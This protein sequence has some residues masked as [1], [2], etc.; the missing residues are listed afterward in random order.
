MFSMLRHLL[1]A[2]FGAIPGKSALVELADHRYN[3]DLTEVERCV[4]PCLAGGETVTL[5]HPPSPFTRCF[6]RNVE[7]MLVK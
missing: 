3:L 6:N 7:G 1:I 2:V 4:P 5:L